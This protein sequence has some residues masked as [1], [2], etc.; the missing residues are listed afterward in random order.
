MD[1]ENFSADLKQGENGIWTSKSYDE[2]SYPFEASD[3]LFDLEDQSYWFQ[4]RNNLLASVI[5]TYH[6]NEQK[7]IFDIG[8][9]NGV[10]AARLAKEGFQPVLVDPSREAAANAKKRGLKYV[11]CTSA[12]SANFKSQSLPGVGLFDVLEHIED[13]IGFLNFLSRKIIRGGILYATVPAF[14][15]LW[16]TEDVYAGHY[17]R[18]TRRT[19][20]ETFLSAGFQV[21]YSSYF[22]RPLP[23]PIFLF[24]SLPYQ[25]G[26][27][28]KNIETRDRRREHIT[29]SNLLSK[30][31]RMALSM[32]IKNVES[33]RVMHF[34]SS[35]VIVAKNQ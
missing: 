16:A 34:G 26:F 24:R 5:K 27:K 32:E 7:V 3:L 22:F 28:E 10:V 9:G 12:Q 33:K 23:V 29:K 20:M 2:I 17:R 6:E 13:D 25:V 15:F 11:I 19:L 35:C 18:Y 21:M 1:L 14:D 31:I 30:I 4:H 8:G